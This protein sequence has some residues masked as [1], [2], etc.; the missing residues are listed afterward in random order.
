MHYIIGTQISVSNAPKTKLRP[1]MSSA[2]IRTASQGRLSGTTSNYREEFTS[3]QVYSIARIF[4]KDEKVCYKF[5]GDKVVELLF[6]SVKQADAFISE[7][8]GE[9][10]PDYEA[11]NRNKSD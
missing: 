10:V 2:Q 4:M 5:V 6:D 9:T 1:G 8:R 3:N 11:F 7:L